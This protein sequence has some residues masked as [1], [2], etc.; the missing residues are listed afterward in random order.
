LTDFQQLPRA[1][2][3]SIVILVAA[4]AWCFSVAEADEATLEGRFKAALDASSVAASTE[5]PNPAYNSIPLT[6]ELWARLDAKE[7]YNI[8][9]ANELKASPT[10]WE[11]YT[12]HGSGTYSAYLP[13]CS[14]SVIKSPTVVTDGG[15]HYLAM[16]FDGHAVRLF[17]DANEVAHV[18]VVRPVNLQGV[19][20]SMTF[21]ALVSG[22]LG[23][24]G[25]IDE[26][27]IS[28][29]IRPIVGIPTEP[30][31]PDENTVGLWHFDS[32]QNKA[33]ADHSSIANLAK[34]IP[35]G[36]WRKPTA[37]PH[38]GSSRAVM[39]PSPDLA[40]ARRSLRLA[41]GRLKLASL[42]QAGQ[43]RDAL[44]ADWEEQFFHL[45]NRIA[46]REKLPAGAA[47][48]VFDDQ[49]LVYPSD[50][51]PLGVVLR[52]TQVLL[53][54]LQSQPRATDLTQLAED[55]KTLQTFS[56][57]MDVSQSAVRKGL[58]LAACALRRKIAFSNP[59][60]DFDQ[61]LFVARGNYQGSRKTG[62]RGTGDLFGQHFA[63]QY[64]AFNSIPGG[65][66]FA[67]RDFT[68]QPQ[69]V[70]L[71]E[72]SI[73]QNGRLEGHTLDHGAFLSPDLSYDAN[74]I[75]FAWTENKEHKW[76]WSKETTWN[77]F[78][79]DSDGSNLVQLTDGPW[80]DFDPC[81]LPN[82]RVAFI[83]ERR[84][85]YIR[86][87]GP[88]IDVPNYVLH[89]MRADGTDVYPL[90]F[91]ETSEWHP[92]V[93][94]NGMLVYTRW[95]Y[96]DRENCLGSN[97]WI[98]HADGRDPRAPHGNYPYPWHTFADNSRRDSRI[99]RPYVEWN[100]RAIPRSHRYVLTAG[101]H[102]G[103]AFGSLVMLDLHQA[104]DGFMS[105]LKRITPYPAFPE[106]ETV[107]R[108]QY[109]FGTPWPLSE[110][111]YLC[112]WWE[113][114][115]L[116]DRFG[117][118]ELLCENSLVFGK[119]DYDM[120]L[121]DPIPLRPRKIPPELPVLTNR[122]QDARPNGRR[123]TIGIRNV[124]DSDIPFPPD[125]KLK[126]LRVT[127]NILKT[128]PPMGVPMIGY[129]AESTPR[130]PLGIVPVEPDGSVYLEA[131]V[132]K[133]L[134][135]QVL[136]ENYMA[137]Q[138]MRSVVYVH[139]GEHLG[140]I[141]CHENRRKTH[142]P[143]NAIPMAMRRPP[144][145]LQPEVGPIEPITY[146]RLVKPVFERSCIP[147]HRD[148]GKGPVEMAYE[149][150]EP[151]VFYFAGGMRG[152][153]VKPIHGGSRTIPGRFGAKNSVMGRALLDEDHRGKISPDDYRRVVLWL[154]SN[155]LRLGAFH[156]EE[157]QVRGEVVWPLLDV[158]PNDP[159]GVEKG[160]TD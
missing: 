87:F 68:N 106:S 160:T 8:L 104:D 53:Q 29:S 157:K 111:F 95:D 5:K 66:L 125:T 17:V 145:K 26:V 113:N 151:S 21:G 80:N 141:G 96:T 139:R 90:S 148:E 94:N 32:D 24:K 41:L 69:V 31:S 18:K 7:D 83:S 116:L 9:V 93:N 103:E 124:Y 108:S 119:T 3:E 85:G 120:R 74:Q 67:V 100:I 2:L 140:C 57:S 92:S 33:F 123:A 77:I 122:G 98:C 81:W 46:G 138:S 133:E 91:Y 134:I 105:Q 50:K 56:S 47:E 156:D 144:S 37:P 147:C 63:T 51:D 78:R 89:G 12:E 34:V 97:F 70:N 72:N 88:G 16:V 112:N 73:V 84:G 14:P 115:Y 45:G 61:I 129:Q 6:V 121:I 158:D 4:L 58:Y 59:L 146:Y 137:V 154:D 117:N 131:P 35:P 107:A 10:H 109:P 27:R 86:C 54:Y 48:Q 114:L 130:I 39:P 126:W 135:F 102:H 40:E 99:G 75:L 101:P 1:G 150:L 60:L 136:D 43:T 128:N 82:G 11:V 155:S 15:W 20:G 153:T 13:G 55:F 143:T 62:P 22:T 118:R 149:K 110:D 49:A 65:G 25:L 132:E 36:R 42:S 19:T 79:V 30:F 142:A 28:N 64:F 23:C 44:V 52:R 38:S 71:L 159:L 127:Q 152:S 76:T